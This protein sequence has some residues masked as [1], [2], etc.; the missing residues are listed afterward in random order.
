MFKHFPIFYLS[1]SAFKPHL[2]LPYVLYTEQPMM[3]PVNAI[4]RLLAVVIGRVC[5]GFPKLPGLFPRYRCIFRLHLRIGESL[6]VAR[7][8][9]ASMNVKNH[10]LQILLVN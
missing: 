5:A 3:R 7:S 1:L 8:L 4:A 10:K 9:K 6:S 2:L